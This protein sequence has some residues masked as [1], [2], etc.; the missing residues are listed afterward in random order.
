[1]TT[2]HTASNYA[3][4]NLHQ[5]SEVQLVNVDEGW[6]NNVEKCYMQLMMIVHMFNDNDD[7]MWCE[8]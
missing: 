1:M 5:E 8:P 6:S 2:Y 4:T 3:T 7:S